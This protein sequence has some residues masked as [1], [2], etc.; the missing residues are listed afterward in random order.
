[1]SDSS[2]PA[3]APALPSGSHPLESSWTIWF[4]KKVSASKMAAGAGYAENLRKLATFRT[5]EE[6]WGVYTHLLRADELPKDSNYHV[7]REGYLP[8]WE[9][10]PFGGCWIIRVRKDTKD[11]NKKNPILSKLWE[12]LLFGTVGEHFEESDVVGCVLAIRPKEDI[13]SIWNKDNEAN[14][15]V[16]FQIGERLKALL[17]LDD[18]STIEYKDNQ[19]SLRDKSSFRNARPY[20][21]AVSK[22]ASAPVPA[23]ATFGQ[24]SSSAAAAKSPSKHA[25]GGSADE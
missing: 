25:S 5:L 23:T 2:A 9:S 1:M 12:T 16:R 21:F 11:G 10:F 18:N 17:T 24:Q 22:P 4:D 13:L 3:S 7:F 15:N 8:M 20:M 6:F 19:S 14:P